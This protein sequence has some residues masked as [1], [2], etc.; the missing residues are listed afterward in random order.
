[1]LGPTLELVMYYKSSF[2][3]LDTVLGK[4]P[5]KFLAEMRE[6]GGPLRRYMCYCLCPSLRA[7]LTSSIISDTA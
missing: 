3:N 4:L 7:A 1:M 6:G 5:V 2:T